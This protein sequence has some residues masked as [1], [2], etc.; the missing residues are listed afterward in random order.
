METGKQ[1]HWDLGVSGLGAVATGTG[2]QLTVNNPNTEVSHGARLLG[3]G[4][5]SAGAMGAPT[6]QDWEGG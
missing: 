1:I 6:R 3:I 5:G 2:Q 4:L